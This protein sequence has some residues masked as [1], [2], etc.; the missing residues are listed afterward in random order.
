MASISYLDYQVFDMIT[1]EDLFSKC[2][3]PQEELLAYNSKEEFVKYFKEKSNIH[4][5]SIGE[6]NKVYH[7]CRDMI[8]DF[9]IKTSILSKDI[10]AIILV[11]PFSTTASSGSIPHCIAKEF[12]CEHANIFI[13]NQACGSS[14]LCMELA[15][16]LIREKN[17]YLLVIST[18]FAPNINGRLS[19]TSIIG[20]AIGLLVLQKNNKG[21]VIIK[22][23]ETQSDGTNSYNKI[24]N[25]DKELDAITIARTGTQTIKRLLKKEKISIDSIFKIIP[26]NINSFAYTNLYSNFLKISPSMFYLDNIPN[27]GHLGDVDIIRNLKD[28]LELIKN[29]ETDCFN[30]LLYGMGGPEGKDKNYHAILVQYSHYTK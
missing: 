24:Y 15:E 6:V 14:F 11:D 22:N 3:I 21:K 13:L 16:N 5:I 18:C 12:N 10:D 29:K 27:G 7:I 19:H 4:N 2:E 20:D 1:I 28:Y 30:I 17:K 25:I 9:F 26:Q 8:E 23:S